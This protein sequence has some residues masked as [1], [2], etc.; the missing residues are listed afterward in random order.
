MLPR[1]QQTY[2]NFEGWWG[3]EGVGDD[4]A[5]QLGAKWRETSDSVIR[6]T[7]GI[8]EAVQGLINAVAAQASA[9]GRPQ[10]WAMDDIADAASGTGKRR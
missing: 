6:T 4:F 9:V 3:E 1:F 2:R 8:T 7:T 5:N 10:E